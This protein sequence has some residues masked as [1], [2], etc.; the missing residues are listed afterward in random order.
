MR[1]FLRTFLGIT[2]EEEED[3]EEEVLEDPTATVSLAV[4]LIFSE[5]FSALTFV[6]FPPPVT[7]AAS[8]SAAKG[9]TALTRFLGPSGAGAEAEAEAEEGVSAACVFL[10]LLRFFLTYSIPNL[11]Y[12]CIDTVVLLHTMNITFKN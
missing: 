9:E 2:I 10:L 4:T 1:S 3:D 8:V 12:I 11:A 6:D 5:G 7:A